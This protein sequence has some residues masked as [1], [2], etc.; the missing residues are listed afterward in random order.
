MKRPQIIILAAAGIGAVLV[1]GLAIY[2]LAALRGVQ[3]RVNTLQRALVVTE[4]DSA[5]TRITTV[6]QRCHLTALVDNVVVQLIPK[7]APPF[8]TSYKSCEQQ[9][10]V[11]EAIV[12]ASPKP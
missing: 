3:G 1:L 11:V 10:K 5:K 4:Y 12:A 7:Y 2:A 8:T 6:K 9:L